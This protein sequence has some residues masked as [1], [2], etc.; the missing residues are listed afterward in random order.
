MAATIEDLFREH[1]SLVVGYLR[2]RT[3]DEAVA[4][5]LAGET[6]YRATRAFLGWRGGSPAAWLL[7]IARNVLRDYV[8]KGRPVV[9]IDESLLPVVAVDD[10]ALDVREVLTRMPR[11]ATSTT[12][13]DL[14]RWLRTRR[15][16]D[17]RR[18]DSGGNQDRGV[19]SSR[20][21]S[22]VVRGGRST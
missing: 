10:V 20:D 9:P 15:G 7:A 3:G 18:F 5:D 22:G 11:C 4:E 1:W 8:R 17:A 16:R 14:H 19:A 12:R 13:A 6:F 2:R 21:I